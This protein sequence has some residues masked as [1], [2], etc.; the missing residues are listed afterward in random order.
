MGLHTSRHTRKNSGFSTQDEHLVLLG[1]E[2]LTAAPN[3]RYAT[4]SIYA[5]ASFQA[6]PASP[7]RQPITGYLKLFCWVVVAVMI[8]LTLLGVRLF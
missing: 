7:V 8:V 2:A 4:R 6:T 1:L 5:T 3:L